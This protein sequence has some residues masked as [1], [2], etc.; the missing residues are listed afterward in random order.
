MS[1]RVPMGEMNLPTRR[2]RPPR[3]D[4]E[5]YGYSGYAIHLNVGTYGQQPH[6]GR[7]PELVPEVARCIHEAA[8][9]SRV[10]VFCYCIMPSH[11]HLVAMVE[12]GGKPLDLFMQSVKVRSTAAA[13]GILPVPLW[14]RGFYDRFVRNDEILM[15]VCLYVLNNPVEAGFVR[16]WHEYPGCW[17]SPE[18]GS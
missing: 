11:L 13:R 2:D 18:M 5:L 4:K 7:H 14:Q 17:L 12:R 16:D 15:Q 3:L 6:F 10:H 8:A 9:A 1:E